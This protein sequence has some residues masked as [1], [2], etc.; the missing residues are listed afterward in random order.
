MLE[1]LWYICYNMNKD[2]QMLH[3][4]WTNLLEILYINIT[5]PYK[6]YMNAI[7]Y[8]YNW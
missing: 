5:L 2:E 4:L 1:V 6:I 8:D 7:E 3:F